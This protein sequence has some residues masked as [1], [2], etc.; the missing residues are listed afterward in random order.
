M[1]R[2]SRKLKNIP[3]YYA[4][5]GTEVEISSDTTKPNMYALN[6]DWM[7]NAGPTR[8]FKDIIEA[9]H[10]ESNE[11]SCKNVNLSNNNYNPKC[12]WG[13]PNSIENTDIGNYNPRCLM[14]DCPNEA[15]SCIPNTNKQIKNNPVFQAYH[16]QLNSLPNSSENSNNIFHT[17]LFPNNTR[18][19]KSGGSHKNKTSEKK[20]NRNKRVKKSKRK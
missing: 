3:T 20:I 12:Y 5:G 8:T 2:K 10:R 18:P 6:H 4:K 7:S 17:Y 11:T 15:T 1:G 16:V 19:I 9:C 14:Y 13:L